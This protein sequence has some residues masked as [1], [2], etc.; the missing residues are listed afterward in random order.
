MNELGGFAPMFVQQMP[1]DFAHED[2]SV[3]V[4]EPGRNRHKVNSGHHANGAKIV[5]QI[6][7][8]DPFKPCGFPR[9]L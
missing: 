8:A 6:M 9:N 4:A 5:A 2:P 3:F 7:K 1:V